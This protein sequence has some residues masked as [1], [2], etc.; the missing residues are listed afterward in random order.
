MFVSFQ[1]FTPE[2]LRFSHNCNDLKKCVCLY[3]EQYH[4]CKMHDLQCVCIW[5]RNTKNNLIALNDSYYIWRL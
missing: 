3:L 4:T 5:L 2:K 1:A